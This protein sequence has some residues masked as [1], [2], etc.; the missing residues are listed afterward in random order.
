MT[1]I[2]GLLIV[3]LCLMLSA[4]NTLPKQVDIP[5]PIK[6]P[7]I[8][9]PAKPYLPIADLKKT[10]RPDQVIK[11]YAASIILLQDYSTE[12]EEIINANN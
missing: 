5:I 6:A 3:S 1:G 10:S 2:N 4:C 11:A 7:H 12:L 9:V 8:D